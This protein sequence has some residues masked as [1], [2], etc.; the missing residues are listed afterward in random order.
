MRERPRY[1]WW[2]ALAT[3]GWRQKSSAT[4]IQPVLGP[5]GGLLTALADIYQAWGEHYAALA[6]DATGHSQ[7]AQHWEFLDPH[8]Q[9]NAWIQSL[10]EPLTTADIWAALRKMKAHR[11]SGGDGIP[12]ELLKACLVE[13]R[14][15]LSYVEKAQDEDPTP[16]PRTPMTNSLELLLNFA[17]SKGM[18][19]EAW[20]ES[21]VVSIPKKGDLTD[22][23]NYRGISLMATILK[24]VCVILITRINGA[25]E[26]RGLFSR[27]QAGFR[28]REEC[29]TQVA[30]VFEIIQ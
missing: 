6:A 11:V 18:V 22:M 25:A 8:P 15:F 1:Y 7:D 21:L 19:A 27:A 3:A 23:N 4:G 10:D 14:A 13:E 16:P 17:Y 24:V 5:D 30:C 20:A 26:E 9:E 2:W 28:Q 29:V 12:T